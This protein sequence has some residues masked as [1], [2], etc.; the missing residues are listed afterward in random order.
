MSDYLTQAELSDKW[1]IP[2]GTLENWRT[3]GVGPLFLKLNQ[4]IRYRPEDIEKYEQDNL[5]VS[6]SQ[7]VHVGGIQ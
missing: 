2:E 3:R 4:Q 6:T 1:D 7:K 5:R